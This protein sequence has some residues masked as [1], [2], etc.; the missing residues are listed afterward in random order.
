MMKIMKNQSQI[1]ISF[2]EK[3]MRLANADTFEKDLLSC[4]SA[5][6]RDTPILIFNFLIAKY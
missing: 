5:L 4:A 3:K 6:K 1:K 2:Q